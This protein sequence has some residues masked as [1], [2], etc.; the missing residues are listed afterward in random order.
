MR[1]DIASDRFLWIRIEHSR[2]AI[3]GGHNLIRYH[4]GNPKLEQEWR[5]KLL[6]TD[7]HLV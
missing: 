2:S 3:D 7:N 6:I 5:Y 4:D 1:D